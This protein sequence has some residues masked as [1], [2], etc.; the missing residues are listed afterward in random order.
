MNS[1][2]RFLIVCTLVIYVFSPV[3]WAADEPP[4]MKRA[5][6]FLGIH[7]DFHAREDCDRV[8]VRTTPAMVELIID[9]VRPDYIQIDCKGHRGYCSYPTKLGIPLADARQT[10][11]MLECDFEHASVWVNLE[12]KEANVN[13]HGLN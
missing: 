11:W 3:A 12:T 6:S 9:K 8:G 5:D 1:F 7:F 4:R 13:W 2:T 10:G